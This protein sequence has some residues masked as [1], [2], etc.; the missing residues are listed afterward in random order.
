MLESIIVVF[1]FWFFVRHSN[2]QLSIEGRSGPHHHRPLPIRRKSR[3]RFSF[4]GSNHY[5]DVPLGPSKF[6]FISSEILAFST[7]CRTL[8][9]S[10]VRKQFLTS[11]SRFADAGVQEITANGRQTS[12]SASAA[13][14]MV[15]DGFRMSR[16]KLIQIFEVDFFKLSGI[17]T[18]VL[19]DVRVEVADPHQTA[20][21][22]L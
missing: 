12:L 9:S 18:S 21:K 22:N 19:A 14:E 10:V 1:C 4:V 6:N 7:V 17:P 8:V 11:T 5:N 16:S 15:Q 20:L 13:A 3:T 2:M